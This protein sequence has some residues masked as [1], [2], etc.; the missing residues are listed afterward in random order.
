MPIYD[1][2]EW[3]VQTPGPGTF[4]VAPTATVVGRVALGEGTSVWFGATIRGDNDTI[5]IGRRVSIQESA[6]LHIDPGFPMEIGDDCIIGHQ[7]TLHGCV[8]GDRVVIGMG[9]IV[10][11]GARIGAGAMIG[12]G[13]LVPPG[14]EI[15]PDAVVLGAPGK[16]VRQV[17][18]DERA[19]NEW[20]VGDYDR[21]WRHYMTTMRAAEGS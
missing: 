4:W 6:V 1:L 17:T 8:I 21:R 13:A 18:D 12:A 9:A 2:G 19:F 20:A 3:K 16:V 11:N 14:K 10:L 7:A 5:R 15:A